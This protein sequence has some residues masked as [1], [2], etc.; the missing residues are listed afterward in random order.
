MKITTISVIFSLFAILEI[1]HTIIRLK[2]E[3]V[4][5]RSAA[6]WLLM[7][8]GVAIFSLFPNLLDTA[9]RLAQM[10]SRMFFV[11][12]ISVF[13][14]FAVV[15]N[16]SSRLDRMQ[17][18]MSKIIQEIAMINYKIEDRRKPIEKKNE[19]HHESGLR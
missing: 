4:G 3:T 19:Q 14:L 18:D 5:I 8:V 11:L 6:V 13:I 15:F 10:Q 7:W 9:I 2:Q 17:R 16:L 12:T 1:C